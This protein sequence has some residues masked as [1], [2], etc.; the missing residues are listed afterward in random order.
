MHFILLPQPFRLFFSC[1]SIRILFLYTVAAMVCGVAAHDAK[2]HL[3]ERIAHMDDTSFF[4]WVQ[5]PESTFWYRVCKI[6]W[7][8]ANETVPK[9][10][11]PQETDG[12][13]VQLC[14]G[15]FA[16]GARLGICDGKRRRVG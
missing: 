10:A 2:C 3:C 5:D 16:A 1:R 15:R 9:S 14:N 13:C 11:S 7:F 8:T 12:R 4:M 6:C